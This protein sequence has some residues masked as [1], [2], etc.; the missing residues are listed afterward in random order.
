MEI[1]KKNHTHKKIHSDKANSIYPQRS[2]TKIV[3]ISYY[4]NLVLLYQKLHV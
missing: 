3:H 1:I 4:V 2:R